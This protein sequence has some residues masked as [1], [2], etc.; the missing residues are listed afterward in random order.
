MIFQFT[1]PMQLQHCNPIDTSNSHKNNQSIFGISAFTNSLLSLYEKMFQKFLTTYINDWD[2]DS[3]L[4]KIAQKIP[5]KCNVLHLNIIIL[6]PG[7]NPNCNENIHNACDLYYE[8]VGIV[9]TGCLDIAC[10]EAIF[11]QLIL[12]KEKNDDKIVRPLLGQWHTSRDMCIILINIFLGYGI[13]NMAAKLSIQFLDKLEKVVDYQATCR[14]L[15]LIWV[16]VG[17]VI[18]K[19]LYNK[20]QTVN[21]IESNNN[22]ILKV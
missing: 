9:N 2:A 22:N 19:Y 18:F 4:E 12:Y 13:A 21:D 1:M 7:N 11:H 6:K 3:F 15:K 8:D 14:V 17:I 20:N 16:A 10:D 5:I